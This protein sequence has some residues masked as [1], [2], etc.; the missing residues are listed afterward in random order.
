MSKVKP[1]YIRYT[2][3]ADVPMDEYISVIV[4]GEN[5]KRPDP[6]T[7]IDNA[8]FVQALVRDW[9]LSQTGQAEAQQ[10]LRSIAMKKLESI[11]AAIEEFKNDG[12]KK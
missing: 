9:Y 2:V 1:R 7:W 8:G 11:N 4:A 12:A 6:K 5:S 3:V 10:I